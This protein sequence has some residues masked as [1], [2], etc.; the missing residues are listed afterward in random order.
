M[1]NPVA[2]PRILVVD[3]EDDI[4]KILQSLLEREGF[5]VW[6]AKSG[7]EAQELIGFLE[8]RAVITDVKIPGALSGLELLRHVRRVKPE[9][10]VIL[11]TGYLKLIE[12]REAIDLG[13][14]GFLIKPFNRQELVRVMLE[15]CSKV[16]TRDS[17]LISGREPARAPAPEPEI[18]EDEITQPIENQ[19]GTAGSGADDSEGS[20]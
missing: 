12:R 15:A 6:G 14:R 1:N 3:D 2:A 18:E 9:L 20:R 10:P 4:R 8:F 19:L 11:M 17:A 5:E 7:T 16:S 13:A